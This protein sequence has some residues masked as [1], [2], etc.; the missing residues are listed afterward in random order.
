MYGCA[1]Q[2]TGKS[3]QRTQSDKGDSLN[4]GNSLNALSDRIVP[5]RA[6]WVKDES[7]L[8]V[9]QDNIVEVKRKFE[10]IMLDCS[11]KKFYFTR[12]PSRRTSVWDLL[13]FCKVSLAIFHYPELSL[14]YSGII[15]RI[16]Y[17]RL[18]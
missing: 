5:D 15:S 16:C 8:S 3:I 6:K 4:G 17:K 11:M 2:Y 9:D 18:L 13:Y 7:C 1:H 12:D 10:E 14:S